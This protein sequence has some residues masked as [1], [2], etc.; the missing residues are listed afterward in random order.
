MKN[1]EEGP[2]LSN[3][4]IVLLGKMC[5]YLPAKVYLFQLPLLCKTINDDIKYDANFIKSVN[6]DINAHYKITYERY[7]DLTTKYN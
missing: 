5:S 6:Q 1:K 4:P 3:W 2:S 7:L